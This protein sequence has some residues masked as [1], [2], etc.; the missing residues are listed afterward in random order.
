MEYG[1]L[2]LLIFVVILYLE[3]LFSAMENKYIGL[4][5]PAAYFAASFVWVVYTAISQQQDI[6]RAFFT[7]VILN[8]PSLIMIAIYRHKRKP[9]KAERKNK[10]K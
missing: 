10:R 8:I 4:I 6:V 2:C 9:P 5:L 3:T 1:I 7:L